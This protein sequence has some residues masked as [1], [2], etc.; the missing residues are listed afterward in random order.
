MPIKKLP[1]LFKIIPLAL[2]SL[3]SHV[4]HASQ[5]ET[6]SDQ[7][8]L[9]YLPPISKR[10]YLSGSEPRQMIAYGDD[11]Y[12]QLEPVS[13][14]KFCRLWKYNQKT[15]VRHL[16]SELRIPCGSTGGR[17]DLPETM[18]SKGELLYLTAYDSENKR[19]IY[20]L[21]MK[22][23]VIKQESN[24][25]FVE[26]VDNSIGSQYPFILILLNDDLFL[27]EEQ[28]NFNLYKLNLA[29]GDAFEFTS[30]GSHSFS[31]YSCNR[32]KELAKSV[33]YKDKLYL[34]ADD[35]C[36]YDNDKQTFSALTFA[37][38]GYTG[39]STKSKPVVMNEKLYFVISE[40][41]DSNQSLALGL[42][43]YSEEVNRFSL[44]IEAD[45]YPKSEFSEL[46]AVEDKLYFV[47]DHTEDQ[48]LWQFT[49]STKELINIDTTVG[50][51]QFNASYL[52]AHNSMLYY[53]T[54]EHGDRSTR[55]KEYSPLTK[56]VKDLGQVRRSSHL[57]SSGDLLLFASDRREGITNASY[58]MEVKSY[59]GT[60]VRAY[61]FRENYASAT[62]GYMT[63]LNGV[64][65]FGA[66][67]HIESSMWGFDGNKVEL[68]NGLPQNGGSGLSALVTHG[69][70]IYFSSFGDGLL[71]YDGETLIQTSPHYEGF[72]RTGFDHIISFNGELLFTGGYAGS[73]E[74]WKLDTSTN[75][76]VLLKRFA[77]PNA[78]TIYRFT[79]HKS[80]LFFM[81]PAGN[82]EPQHE[83]WSYDGNEFEKVL[84]I[85]DSE[86][87]ALFSFDDKLF[88]ESDGYLSSYDDNTKSIENIFA[89]GGLRVSST[90]SFSAPQELDGKLYFRSSGI[91]DGIEYKF[92]LWAYDPDSKQVEVVVPGYATINEETVVPDLRLIGGM[93]AKFDNKLFFFASDKQQE[94]KLR[95]YDPK[96][97]TVELIANIEPA[98]RGT[99]AYFGSELI[100]SAGYYDDHGVEFLA[101]LVSL[102]AKS[103]DW[104]DSDGD[105]YGDKMDR[106]PL[107][108]TEWR[109]SDQDGYGNNIDEFHLD[110]S[111]W[112]DTD[113]DGYGDN[114][115]AFPDDATEW[116]D[117]DRDGYGDNS[118]AFPFNPL[119]WLDTDGDGHGDN[120]DAFP[121]D[122]SRWEAVAVPEPETEEP[123]STSGGGSVNFFLLF[124]MACGLCRRFKGLTH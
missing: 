19:A 102:T 3:I 80:K 61:D 66:D 107:D 81:M 82:G 28:D 17:V 36:V 60:K 53:F 110:P 106:F 89:V 44:E 52:T 93:M 86:R 40:A 105:S 55:L 13:G 98:G 68:K 15:N 50:E 56:V 37:E 54:N 88:F 32:N 58:E 57:T 116:L 72:P 111:E 83:I 75:V 16:F 33:V 64:L 9:E 85:G 95:A 92:S 114:A 78:Q 94:T 1:L 65:Y 121:N 79:K 115:D 109:D 4:V 35:W 22:T 31:S 41:N 47:N 24:S 51:T 48:E 26:V 18:I 12:A 6:I 84:S 29:T 42:W 5:T 100:F 123:A 27:Q 59:D 122:P 21:N 101:E 74:L 77:N 118:D 119:E 99:V 67:E 117:T 108:S 38:Q 23:S 46:V 11:I 112:K 96:T 70:S 73:N 104:V 69:D 43:S 91:L 103:E 62:G 34:N 90:I 14:D 63:E 25:T 2:V 8:E 120:S 30:K 20:S 113:K 45:Q 10:A 76:P 49:P 7:Y 71:R 97:S 87:H 124:V 39:R